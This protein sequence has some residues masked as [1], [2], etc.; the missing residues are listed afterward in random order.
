MEKGRTVLNFNDRA[1]VKACVGA[2]LALAVVAVAWAGGPPWKTK[3]FEQWTESDVSKVL[4]DSPWAKLQ[5]VPAEWKMN[6]GG[7]GSDMSRAPGGTA[8]AAEG[9]GGGAEGIGEQPMGT[10]DG[11]AAYYLRWNS[12]RT[13][14]EALVRDAILSGKIKESDAGKYLSAPITDYEVLVVGPDMTPFQHVTPDELKVRSSLRGQKSKIEVHPTNVN[15]VK[16][17][18]GDR[19]TAVVFSFPRKTAEGKDVA[20]AQEKGLH[21]ECKPKGISLATTFDPRKMADAKGPDF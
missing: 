15:M 6:P 4:H 10:P 8:A 5:Y 1:I 20:A 9:P 18:D 14:R 3:P 2:L 21:F 13:V 12:S 7:S 17:P 19:V 11:E 16:S